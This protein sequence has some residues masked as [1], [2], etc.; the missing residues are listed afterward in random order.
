MTSLVGSSQSPPLLLY[1]LSQK[2]TTWWRQ[3]TTST[4]QKKR[5][6][7]F[8]ID[9]PSRGCYYFILLLKLIGEKTIII[10]ECTLNLFASIYLCNGLY[11]NLEI[12]FPQFIHLCIFIYI[13]LIYVSAYWYISAC[14]RIYTIYEWINNDILLYLIREAIFFYLSVRFCAIASCCN[15]RLTFVLN[16]NKRQSQQ[17]SLEL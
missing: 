13:S 5:L 14:L 6:A 11:S 2:M 15:F 17:N 9:S 7:Q 8:L 16:I 4:N 12:Q 10:Y 3:K 1:F